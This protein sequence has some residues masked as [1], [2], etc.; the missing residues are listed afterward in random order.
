[1]A[2]TATDQPEAVLDALRAAES[3]SG[4]DRVPRGRRVA[5]DTVQLALRQDPAEVAKLAEV[6][7]AAKRSR[8]RDADNGGVTR[9]AVA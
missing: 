4:G 6:G 8:W 9:T 7:A 3:P 1:M 5:S 2:W